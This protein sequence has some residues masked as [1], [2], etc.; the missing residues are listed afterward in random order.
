MSAKYS[1]WRSDKI[2]ALVLVFTFAVVAVYVSKFSK[3][4]FRNNPEDWASSAAYVSGLLTP[5]IS[6]LARYI[7]WCRY[8]P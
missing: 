6:V 8:F 3:Y 5:V 4:S 1:S 2:L 7:E